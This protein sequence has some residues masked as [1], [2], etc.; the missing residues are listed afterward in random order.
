MNTFAARMQA[1][2][3]ERLG[4]AE[5]WAERLG[6]SGG[7]VRTIMSRAKDDPDYRPPAAM[8]AALAAT[9]GVSEAW[10]NT[11]E[12]EMGAAGQAAHYSASQPKPLVLGEL[13][14]PDGVA[15]AL[16]QT[17]RMISSAV[18][19]SAKKPDTALPL[20]RLLLV[21]WRDSGTEPEDFEAVA[22]IIGDNAAT[23]AASGAADDVRTKVFTRWLLA[24]KKIR[25]EGKAVTLDAI[26]FEA[27]R[28]E[29]RA[30]SE[31]SPAD[32]GG[33]RSS[34]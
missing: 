12:G 4:T 34:A 22:H 10:L 17:Y 2:V 8:M 27:Y 6:K 21:A 16:Q 33:H 30:E 18:G 23:L 13:H 15:G 29:P 24:A 3:R 14:G 11:G 5:A 26:A 31:A 25:E 19:A 20:I 28:P 1:L 32:E 9:A 7:Y